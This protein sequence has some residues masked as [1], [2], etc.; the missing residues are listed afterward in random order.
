MTDFQWSLVIPDIKE[1][2]FFL[3]V[4]CN[5]FSCQDHGLPWARPLE[6][7]WL[8]TGGSWGE[9]CLI[10]NRKCNLIFGKLSL[11]AWIFFERFKTIWAHENHN[12]IFWK[13]LSCGL[14]SRS[15]CCDIK[16]GCVTSKHKTSLDDFSQVCWS[17]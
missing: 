3:F 14:L 10:F 4:Y 1:K 16:N 13:D 2:L 9:N 7:L 17:N 12:L 11:W 15:F 6:G 5:V 8:P